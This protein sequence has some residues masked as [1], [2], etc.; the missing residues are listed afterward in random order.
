MITNSKNGAKYIKGCLI[1]TRSLG[2]FH[3]KYPEFASSVLKFSKPYI[4]HEPNIVTVKVESRKYYLVV[5]SDGLWDELSDEEVS[6]TV[7]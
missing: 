6:R 4:T 2:D 5:G 7:L 3:L 1:P